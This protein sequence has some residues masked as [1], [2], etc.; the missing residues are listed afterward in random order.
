MT[1]TLPRRPAA[2]PPA[3]AAPPGHSMLGPVLVHRRGLVTVV[4]LLVVL[5][6]V[7]AISLA[8]G[9]VRIDPLRAVG[10][11][12]GTGTPRDLLVVG[13][14][15]L[16]RVEAGL[17]VGIALGLSGCLMQTLA[18]NRLATP[19]T[20]GLNNGA[21]AFAVASVVSVPMSL[22]PPAM[23]LTGA[24][25]AAALTL[26]LSGGAGPRG[27]RFL[28]VGLG[29]G[30]VFGAVTNLL[31]ARA[32]IDTA[33]AAMP[34]TVGTLNTTTGP[35]VRLLE[36]GLLVGLPTAVLLGR[37]LRALRFPDAVATGLGVPLGRARIAVLLTSV[38]AA[39]LSVAVAGPL[40]MV[41]LA[42]PEAARRLTGPGPVPVVASALTG[43]V[44]TLL[45]DL[46]GRTAF[47]P[48][49]IPAGL[50]TAVVGGPYLLWLLLTT[51][52]R[53]IP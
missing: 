2:R 15:R 10:A 26:G 22:A 36:L 19:E 23:A 27:Y 47:A 3:V 6:A 51:R 46:V 50:V 9:S 32:D 18:R 5:G 16:P 1:A 53:T 35:A 24:A 14:L 37:W 39:G 21:T 41:A 38:G 49:E 52:T 29:L 20:T 25:T 28:V 11:V 13:Q 4:G 31:L 12:F 42:A 33:N 48:L 43:A 30:A 8:V 45:A 17:A 40:G 44:F 34:W 7:V